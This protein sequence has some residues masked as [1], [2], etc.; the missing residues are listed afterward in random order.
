MENG[1]RRTRQTT[2]SPT[3]ALGVLVA[4]AGLVAL[5]AIGLGLVLAALWSLFLWGWD[6]VA[7]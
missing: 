1:G 2:Y 3:K 4:L 7:W 6:A 5:A